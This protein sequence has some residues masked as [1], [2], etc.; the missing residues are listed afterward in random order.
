MMSEFDSFDTLSADCCPRVLCQRHMLYR[1]HGQPSTDCV[2][3]E[4]TSFAKLS[5]SDVIT[6]WLWQGVTLTVSNTCTGELSVVL[7]F[8]MLCETDANSAT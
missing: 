5:D 8:H 3:N 4:F 1:P 2:S 6:P 7:H